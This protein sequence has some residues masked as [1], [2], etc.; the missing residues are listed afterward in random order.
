MNIGENDPYFW[1]QVVAAPGTIVSALT[2]LVMFYFRYRIDE[3]A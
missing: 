2:L 3:L 1:L